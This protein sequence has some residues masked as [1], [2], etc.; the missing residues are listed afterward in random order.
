MSIVLI[1]F[2][3]AR[4]FGR[5]KGKK[6]KRRERGRRLRPHVRTRP[7]RERSEPMSLTLGRRR[8]SAA[9]RHRSAVDA[10]P[11]G[12]AGEID[13][14]GVCAWFSGRLVLELGQPA[15]GALEG[16]GADRP[17]GMREVD[18]PA[19]PQPDARGRPRCPAGRHGEARRPGHLRP[20]QRAVDT[21]RHIGMV[22]QKPNPFPAMTIADN[23]LSG[24]KFSRLT[25]A[26][27]DDLVEEMLT[28][29]GLWNEVKDRLGELGGAL[30]GGQQQRLCIARALAVRPRVLLMDEPCSALDPTSTLRI[31]RTIKD[32]ADEVTVVIVTHNMQQAQ[33][34]SDYCAFFLA[35]ENQPGRVVE[36][37]TTDAD[38]RRPNRPED[39]GLCPRPIRLIALRADH[40]AT[41]SAVSVGSG[42]AL[43]P[44][45]LAR[46]PRSRRA[47]RWRSPAPA[48]SMQSTGSSFAGVAIQQ[49]VG[50]A[51]T[52]YGLNINWQVSSSVIGLNNFAQNQVDFAASDIPYSSQQATYYPDQSPTSTCP[53]WPAGCPS[54]TT[55]PATT[56]SDHQPG[57]QC[58]VAEEIFLGEITNWNDP[59]IDSLNPAAAPATCP[60]PEDHPRLPLRRIRRELPA[61]RLLAARG[62]RQRRQL[63]RHAEHLPDRPGPARPTAIW[64]HPGRRRRTLRRPVP[65]LAG[66]QPRRARTARTT[67]PTTSRPSPAHGAITYVET[68]YAK[69]HSLPVASLVNAS[70]NAVQPTSLNVAT[71]LEAAILH[72]DLTQDLT[73]VYTNP[74]ANAYPLSAY[75]YFVTP[76][77]PAAR[78]RP[79]HASCVRPAT[80]APSTFSPAK[81]QALGPVRGLH[82]LRRPGADGPPRLLA[83]APQPGPGGLQR[84][85]PAQRRV[86]SPRPRPRPT[87]EPLRGR[88]TPLPGEPVIQGQPGGGQ[89]GPLNADHRRRQARRRRARAIG[90]L[91]APPA[92]EQRRGRVR[93]AA[94]EV[95]D[96]AIGPPPGAHRGADRRRR[97]IGSTARSSR[98]SMRTDP[99]GSPGPAPSAA[100][101]CSIGGTPGSPTWAGRFSALAVI[102]LPPLIASRR[103]TRAE[104]LDPRRVGA[105]RTGRR[106][107]R[108][109]LPIVGRRF[110]PTDNRRRHRGRRPGCLRQ[111]RRSRWR[112]SSPGRHPCACSPSGQA[113]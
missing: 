98:C 40:D 56:A 14:E 13:A 108:S 72:P 71:A 70:G 87:A 42:P 77:S 43:L 27:R 112:L 20:G 91:A 33:R 17:L 105:A 60:T 58:P 57:P 78:R 84:H 62:R 44:A 100:M 111:R 12:G 19:H 34:V 23:V 85:R 90:R 9:D 88:E 29:A 61:L 97:A 110:P 25:P 75:S 32:I 35:E 49:W 30:S 104:P 86:A 80:A 107:G 3:A 37:G 26:N 54:C 65:R 89:G 11:L 51:S 22:F 64:P 59:A 7:D 94:A 38:V 4:I 6:R 101:H 28:K 10:S 2:V 63:R 48:R 93:R 67:P 66:Q 106:R 16:D 1:L 103:R 73:S 69:E 21:R 41:S 39:G 8:T 31:E 18:L 24:L 102:V 47:R 55:S 74:L 45:V 53:T 83:A 82:R 36:S 113:C 5:T 50:Q 95:V 96:P 92:P 79:R 52:L 81:G 68:A 46:A 76:C 109:R 15:D 99:A